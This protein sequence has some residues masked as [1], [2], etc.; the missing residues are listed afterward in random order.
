M[1]DSDEVCVGDVAGGDITLQ[2]AFRWD[3]GEV[4]MLFV[5]TSAFYWLL[6]H[7]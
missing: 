4:I 6:A 7:L 1:L 5:G 3:D 2:L